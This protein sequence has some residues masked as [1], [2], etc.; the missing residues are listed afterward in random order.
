MFKI[1]PKYYRNAVNRISE[2]GFICICTFWTKKEYVSDVITEENKKKVLTIGNLYTLEGMKYVIKNIFLCPSVNYLIFTGNDINNIKDK[3]KKANFNLK[4]DIFWNY[5]DS[6]SIFVDNYKEINATI[7]KLEKKGPWID[8]IVE[9]EDV[10]ENLM[11]GKLQSEIQGFIVRDSNLYRMW[12][13]ALTKIKLFGT[14]KQNKTK[15][16]ISLMSVLTDKIILNENM[17]AIEIIDKYLP[18]VLS[19]TPTEGLTYTYGSRLHAKNQINEV[20]ASLRKNKDNRNGISVTWNAET[21]YHFEPP[22]LILIDCKIQENYLYMT[23]YF[24]SH[25]IYKGYCMNIIALQSLQEKIV[26]SLNEDHDYEADINDKKSNEKEMPEFKIVNNRIEILPRYPITK[27]ESEL[28]KRGYLTVISNS[29]HVY[30]QDFEKLEKVNML[31]C[32]LDARGYFI[33]DLD[34]EE[35]KISVTLMNNNN[36]VVKH[37]K[38]D[39]AIK[40]RDLCQP[41]ISEISHAL[42]LGCELQRAKECL[43]SGKEY[44]QV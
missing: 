11:K 19:N 10:N 20:I 15:E 3:I 22:C 43:D 25:D 30:E 7:E 26:N 14:Y 32:N 40:L 4:D 39:D 8:N 27:P 17:P 12:Q 13:R 34:R 31:D 18:Q 33:I 23:A 35:K 44:T 41:Y 16:I 21:D 36:E 9:F 42:Y 37:F 5:F 38:E 6:H 29:A 24:R 1:F 28:I 2:E